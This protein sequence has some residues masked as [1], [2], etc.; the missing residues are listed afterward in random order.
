MTIDQ[1]FI[2]F[3]TLCGLI[4][5]GLVALLPQSR[6]IGIPPYFGVLLFMAIFEI[7]AFARG[8]GAPGSVIKMETR[9]IGFLLAVVLIAVLPYLAGQPMTGLF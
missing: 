1:V 3:M 7:A 5:G 6:S 4:V 8:R 2:G 9:L